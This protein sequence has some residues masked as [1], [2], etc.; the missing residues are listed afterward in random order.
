MKRKTDLELLKLFRELCNDPNR[1]LES[2]CITSCE[3]QCVGDITE[4]EEERI[5]EMV[6]KYGK[7]IG[8]YQ[9]SGYWWEPND[10]SQRI[11]FLD[12]LIKEME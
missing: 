12:N 8:V 1:R 2:L 9:S 5:D 4:S 3:M 11:E 10:W 7:K 6:K